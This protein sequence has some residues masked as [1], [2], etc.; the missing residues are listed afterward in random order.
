[1]IE[2]AGKA[3][4]NLPGGTDRIHAESHSAVAGTAMRTAWQRAFYRRVKRLRCGLEPIVP[5][6]LNR[7]TI[8]PEPAHSEEAHYDDTFPRSST[9]A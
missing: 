7:F 4:L 6:R 8:R 5:G 2:S 9:R 3:A 1:L